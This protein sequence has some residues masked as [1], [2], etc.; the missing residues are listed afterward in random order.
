M[1]SKTQ[2]Q[3][4]QWAM[5]Y[6]LKQGCKAVR[7]TLYTDSEADL[8][9]RDGKLDKLQQSAEIQ[10]VIHV[11]LDGK[12]GS[13]STNRLEKRELATFIDHALEAVRYLSP[14]PD[15]K[16]PASSLYYKGGGDNLDLVDAQFGKVST[17]DKI[18]WA[19]AAC[20]EIMGED[21]RILSVQAGWN[22]GLSCRYLADSQGFEGESAMTYYSLAVSV[23]I[24]G[25]GDAK[26]ESFW[27]DQALTL[28]EL[29]Q[30]GIGKKALER[31][32]RKIGQK[33]VASG[34]YPMLVDKLNSGQLFAPILS[35]LSGY[36]IQQNNSFLIHK[37]GEKNFS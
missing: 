16:L 3:L 24:Q 27:Y 35:A 8:E 25:E 11:F 5:Q 33:K 23:S 31:A 29:Q 36:A 26:P 1:I 7:V 9:I 6:G 13:F 32:L 21:P 19:R 18:K 17:E 20:Q 2:K 14:D 15:R 30:E 22:D 28:E 4:A 10:L 37:K 12:Y 34:K